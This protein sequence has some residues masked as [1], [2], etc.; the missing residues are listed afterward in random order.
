MQRGTR[1]A[2]LAVVVVVGSSQACSPEGLVGDDDTASG[3]GVMEAFAAQDGDNLP[4]YVKLAPK[5]VWAS[6][7]YG[8]HTAG[9]AVDGD[10]GTS[11]ISGGYAT[12]WII[13]DLGTVKS[14]ARIRLLVSQSPGGQTQHEIAVDGALVETIARHTDAG[15]WIDVSLSP[16]AGR[17]IQITT[18]SSPS[19]VAWTEIEIYRHAFPGRKPF[20][21]QPLGL[22]VS[23]TYAGY[24]AWNAVDGNPNSLWNAGG[25][26]PQWIE[27]DLGQSSPLDRLRLL[28]SQSPSGWL[29]FEVDV[30]GVL[31]RTDGRWAKDNEWLE[32]KLMTEGRR[33]RVR[34]TAS[35]SWVALREIEIYR[36]DPTI[37][38]YHHLEYFGWWDVSLYSQDPGADIEATVQ[39]GA[40]LMHVFADAN[41]VTQLKMARA[42]GAKA[43]VFLIDLW[44]T[45]PLRLKSNW[46]ELWTEINNRITKD[47]TLGDTVVA[48]N[49]HD[50]P[51]YHGAT[52][53]DLEALAGQIRADLAGKAIAGMLAYPTV[54]ALDLVTMI[55]VF[56][57]LSCHCYQQLGWPCSQ[58]AC[59]AALISAFTRNDQRLI[60]VPGA[61]AAEPYT[62]QDVVE[63]VAAYERRALMDDRYIAVMPFTWTAV[64][65]AFG[66]IPSHQ[67]PLVEEHLSQWARRITHP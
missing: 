33:L 57:W 26:P 19:W 1:T 6:G 31:A 43:M 60:A 15:Q 23:S 63:I 65:P 56:D 39:L 24:P 53:S 9:R 12:Q 59:D 17:Y 54:D 44:D 62:E 21:V 50:E 7:T 67:L 35:A 13:A 11:W 45:N 5:S 61:F 34:T 18:S 64:D 47:P 46:R 3:P 55:G 16:V 30:D 36:P 4:G 28:P 48:F 20:E 37:D 14:I 8:P 41:L 49:P 38:P 32:A 27:L 58:D 52:R 2:Y 42:S 25:F 66:W 51:Y 29:A 10:Q 40:N 22:R